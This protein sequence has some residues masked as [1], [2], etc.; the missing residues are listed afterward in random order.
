MKRSGYPVPWRRPSCPR[1]NR[2][3][4]LLST[5]IEPVAACA[6]HDAA[7]AGIGHADCGCGRSRSCSAPSELARDPFLLVRRSAWAV[8]GLSSN[9]AAVGN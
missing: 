3:E 4:T 7:V 5:G 8:T 2:W 1:R 6:A 9:D